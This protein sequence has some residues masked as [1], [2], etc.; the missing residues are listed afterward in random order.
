VIAMRPF[1]LMLCLVFWALPAGAWED[2]D[3]G[4]RVPDPPGWEIREAPNPRVLVRFHGPPG[5]G[6]RPSL[7]VHARETQ[8]E[9]DRS[10]ALEVVRALAARLEG[11]KL[12]GSRTT[13]VQGL[14][15]HRLGYR[16]GL[17]GHEFQATQVFWV[18]DGRLYVVTLTGPQDRY[19]SLLPVL[20]RTLEEMEFFEPAQAA[21]QS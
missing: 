5:P 12:L 8:T 7:W 21:G 4:V 15:A 18:R 20:D 3:L 6:P 2:S 14:P 1:V 19:S 16:A 10:L 9:L 13:Q 11:F 17:A